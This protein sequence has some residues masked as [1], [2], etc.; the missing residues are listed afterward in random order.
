MSKKRQDVEIC[1]ALP[2]AVTPLKHDFAGTCEIAAH[3]H[4]EHQLIYASRGIMTVWTEEGSWVVPPLRAVWIPA[5]TPHRVSIHGAVSMRTLY[6]KNNLVRSAPRCCVIN[7]SPLLRELILH[8][9]TFA[10]LTRRAKAQGHLIDLLLDQLDVMETEPLQ[11]LYPSDD[12]GARVARSLSDN[13]GDARPLHVVCASA[14]ASKRTIERIFREETHMTLGR[15]R[16][17]LRLL[18]S[19]HLLAAGEKISRV[20][21]DL[22]YSTTSAFI[23]MFRKALGTTPRQYFAAGSRVR[24]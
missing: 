5:R 2:R 16:Q 20:A 4:P 18:R 17:Q 22:G 11:L 1:R 12:R 6:V 24:A 23:S 8:I 3:L 14:G 10:G 7:V 9:C 13:P 15:W 21:A 19:L